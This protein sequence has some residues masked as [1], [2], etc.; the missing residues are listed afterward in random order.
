M[1]NRTLLTDRER[2][3]RHVAID[4]NTEC[5]NWTASKRGKGYGQFGFRGSMRRAHRVAFILFVGEIPNGLSV[6]HRCDNRLCVNPAHL[7][8][9]TVADNNREA[10]IKGRH[11]SLGINP[12]PARR[13]QHWKAKLTEKQ[14]SEIRLLS[15]QGRSLK[16][17]A[18]Q[19]HISDSH[20]GRIVHHKSWK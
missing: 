13:E 5:W 8:I 9:G 15:Q 16:S 20:V 19:F 4:K 14:I 7:W 10:V 12:N 17:I 11:V 6:L 1:P 2:F 18:V 3:L